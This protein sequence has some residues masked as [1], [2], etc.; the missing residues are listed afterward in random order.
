MPAQL[1]VSVG[2]YSNKGRKEINQD[3]HGVSIP[4]EPQLTSKGIAIALADG[5]S[6]SD[7]GQVASEATVTGFLEDYFCTSEAWSVKKS[8]HQVLSATNS[9]L[10]SQSQ[11]GQHRYD[12][13][14][15]QQSLGQEEQ[16]FERQ[17]NH[18]KNEFQ[19]HQP[20]AQD[21]HQNGQGDN[22]FDQEHD[23]SSERFALS[24]RNPRGPIICWIRRSF[25]LVASPGA[26]RV[27]RDA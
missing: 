17:K 19:E 13:D 23:F 4:E 7:V 16:Q 24:P 6:S 26:I 12:K 14:Q 27:T 20:N 8:A 22:G 5:I 21:H 2:Q 11:Q 25:D 15:S 3:F 1:K 9:W 18:G 10:Y